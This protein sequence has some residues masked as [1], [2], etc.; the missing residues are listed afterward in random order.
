MI[1]KRP[2]VFT[3]LFWL[4]VAII[5]GGLMLRCGFGAGWDEASNLVIT[6]CRYEAQMWVGYVDF[7]AIA[8]YAIWAVL[9][10]KRVGRTDD[11]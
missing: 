11:V 8:I 5:Q 6:D 2:I 1:S 3:L 10:I 4:V 9:A 7:L